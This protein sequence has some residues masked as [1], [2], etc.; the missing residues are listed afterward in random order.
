MYCIYIYIYVYTYIYYRYKYIYI[1]M[2][3]R[4]PFQEWF[5]FSSIF[6][7]C[8]DDAQFHRFLFGV[9]DFVLSIVEDNSPF[10][11]WCSKRTSPPMPTMTYDNI[12]QLRLF[13]QSSWS[14]RAAIPGWDHFLLVSNTVFQFF[15]N[16]DSG[17]VLFSFPPWCWIYFMILH[18]FS[19][20]SLGCYFQP[21]WTDQLQVGRTLVRGVRD[22]NHSSSSYIEKRLEPLCRILKDQQKVTGTPGKINMEPENTPL[23]KEKH[24]P[25]HHFQVPAANLGGCNWWKSNQHDF[26]CVDPKWGWHYHNP[27]N[28]A[29]ISRELV[30][31]EGSSMWT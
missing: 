23:E 14:S 21:W 25:N 31:A 30:N 27:L 16:P 28:R 26:W 22:K 12:C 4:V 15:F 7:T 29:S 9:Q 8:N 6:Q 17:L 18:V 19:P 1:H 3:V 11:V 20:F 10:K 13:N 5:P 2:Y 24:L